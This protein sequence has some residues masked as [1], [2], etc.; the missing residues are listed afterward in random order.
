[1]DEHIHGTSNICCHIWCVCCLPTI[2]VSLRTMRVPL[3]TRP[4]TQPR[5]GMGK[6]EMALCGS[7]ETSLRP[8][9][10]SRESGS[11]STSAEGAKADE[12]LPSTHNVSQRPRCAILILCHSPMAS[13]RTLLTTVTWLLGP[14]MRNST[15]PPCS[16]SDTNP[17]FLS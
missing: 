3:T 2:F 13:M 17:I 14:E 6:P 1:M 10:K 5:N 15:T 4:R 11:T 8:P 9:M 12:A 7:L 16:D